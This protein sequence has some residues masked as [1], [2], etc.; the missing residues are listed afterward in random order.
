MNG[1]DEDRAARSQVTLRLDRD[2]L[3]RIDRLADE[4]GVDRTELVR[5]LL[6]DGLAKRRGEAALADYATGR[7]SAWAAAQSAGVDLY[8]ML[9]R[10]AEAGVPYR[11]DPEALD[12][13]GRGSGRPPPGSSSAP[14]RDG[15]E[16][17]ASESA[18]AGLRAR[19]RPSV[20][21]LLFVGE[22]SPA[23]GTHF[24][25]ADS[26][27]YRATR[28][29]FGAAFAVGDPPE[30]DAFL[31]WFRDLG[32]WL[33]DVA[34]RPVNRS[35][36]ETRTRVVGDGIPALAR[37]IE[38]AEPERIVVVLRRIAP[39]VR[40]AA[41]TA[42]FDDRAIDVLPFPTRQ[43]RPVYVNQLA[44][45]VGSVLGPGSSVASAARPAAAT[46]EAPEPYGPPLLHEVVASVLRGRG[47]RWMTPSEIAREIAAHD[48][49][50]RPSDGRHPPPNQISARVRSRAYADLFQTSDRGVRLRAG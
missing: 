27:L 44:G 33:V 6:A 40:K 42:G 32:C 16:P 24:Y 49:W 4:T 10:I 36:E 9:D 28:E 12:R 35:T 5:R 50:R 29:A 47:N 41:A 2:L 11:V 3:E 21:R 20:T 30:G 25:R 8:E 1:H 46:A 48:M 19:Y 34:E 13:L 31:G 39:A 45:I 14:S 43:W 23:G 22:S 15:G 7:R 38:A 17:G 26:N 37:T 18:I